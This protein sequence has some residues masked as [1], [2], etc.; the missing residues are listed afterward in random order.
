MFATSAMHAY[1]HQWACQIVYNPRMRDGFGLTDGE[2]VER[3]W[4][5]LR[6]LIGITRASARR[7]RIWLIDRQASSIGLELRNDLGDW[8]RRRLTKGVE[9]HATKAKDALAEC[10]VPMDELWSQWDLQK[11]SQ[12]SVRARMSNHLRYT[13]FSHCSFLR[14]ACSSEK[15]ARYGIESTGRSRHD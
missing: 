14:C 13:S 8:I 4:S 7:R 15:G 2:G 9:G 6:K 12:L 3:L 1:A 11:V 5:R 10:N